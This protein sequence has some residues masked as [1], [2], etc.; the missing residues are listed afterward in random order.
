MFLVSWVYKIT[1]KK[2][3]PKRCLIMHKTRDSST[4]K[5]NT[6][7]KKSSLEFSY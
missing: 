4:V 2:I 5:R 6:Q 1:L 3:K 7:V